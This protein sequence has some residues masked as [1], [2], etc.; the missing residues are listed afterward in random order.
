MAR[1]WPRAAFMRR[2]GHTSPAAS[3]PAKEPRLLKPRH[4]RSRIEDRG[5][6]IEDRG[7]RIED[8]GSRIEDRGSRIEDRGSKIE[9]HH[10]SRSSIFYPRSSILDPGVLAVGNYNG[11]CLLRMIVSR[12]VAEVAR[13]FSF[14]GLKRYCLN[15]SMAF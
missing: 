2:S 6:R 1:S 3:S 13:P 11:S 4:N 8:R 10:S 7:S 14:G 9:C 15:A 5:S 12:N